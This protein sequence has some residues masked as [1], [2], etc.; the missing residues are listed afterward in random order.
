MWPSAVQNVWPLS[1]IHHVEGIS[2]SRTTFVSNCAAV[3]LTRVTN[4]VSPRVQAAASGDILV[5][6]VLSSQRLS[7]SGSQ[8]VVWKQNTRVQFWRKKKSIHNPHGLLYIFLNAPEIC[9]D[10]NTGTSCK[11]LTT[12]GKNSTRCQHAVLPPSTTQLPLYSLQWIL[13]YKDRVHARL[14]LRFKDKLGCQVL[15]TFLR[16]VLRHVF[17]GVFSWP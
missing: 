5:G 1:L 2:R 9:A 10:K 12:E 13:C 16:H 8:S 14:M 17:S 7:V 11:G 15:R 4:C 6:S 3:L